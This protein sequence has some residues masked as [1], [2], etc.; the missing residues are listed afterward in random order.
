MKVVFFSLLS[1]SLFAQL[2]ADFKYRR[3]TLQMVLIESYGFPNYEAVLNS[4]DKLP[5]PDKYDKHEID[6]NKINV[7]QTYITDKDLFDA[8]YL[9]DT[10]KGVINITMAQSL[11]KPLRYLNNEYTLAVVEPKED[12]VYQVKLD[13]A[14]KESKLGLAMVANWFNYNP[15]TKKFNMEL[16]QK[17]GFYNASTLEAKIAQG[18]VRGYAGLGDAG[19]QLINNTFVTFTKLDFVDNSQFV[20]TLVDDV[21][22]TVNDRLLGGI[23]LNNSN[24]QNSL[25]ERMKEGYSLWSKTWLY[26]LKWNDEIANIFYTRYWNKPEEFFKSDLFQLE[27]VGFQF[28]QSLVTYKPGQ[29]RSNEEL[30]DIVLVRNIDNALAELQKKHDVFKPKVPVFS[31]SPIR[32]KIGLK[33]GLEGGETFEVLEMVFNSSTQTTEYKKIG[34]V[35]SKKGQIWD[36]R[37][38]AGK[39]IDENGNI[40]QNNMNLNTTEFTGPKNI[41]PGMLLRLVK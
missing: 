2:P 20:G 34:T 35:K 40:I 6:Y 37:Y 10:V 16:I 14:I 32:A 5:F 3:S 28:N 13:K 41:E 1:F 22:N 29:K 15:Q 27:F 25:S 12:E 31:T 9:R 17:R 33:E 4:W 24:N 19:E 7:D 18:Q 38:F 26:K 39:E 30:I 23:R 21:K 8:G 36:N 11:K